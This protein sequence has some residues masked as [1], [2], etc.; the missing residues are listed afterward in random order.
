MLAAL[1]SIT[2]ISA[3]TLLLVS[4]IAVFFF[5][6]SG[7]LAGAEAKLDPFGVIAL[8]AAVGLSGGIV[9]DTMLGVPATVIFDWRI[10][11]SVLC[12]GIIAYFASAAIL[13]VRNS[14]DYIE[15]VS[16]SMFCVIG[17]EIA[18]QHHASAVASAILG[19]LTA[20]SGG[21]V[22]DIFLRRIPEL[23]REGFYGTPTL[24]GSIVV[25]VGH[26]IHQNSLAWL[27]MSA[28]LCLV[29]RLLGVWFEVNLP[30]ARY[31]TSK[32]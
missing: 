28:V 15:S 13:R 9:R 10:V 12:A 11:L 2:Q 16:V 18:I 5:A 25:V 19:M 3:H 30:A 14:I 7:G 32:E 8:A 29:A 22:R 27:A 26:E 23:F 20:V 24:L 6:L 31:P 1:T 17:T 4:V 21:I